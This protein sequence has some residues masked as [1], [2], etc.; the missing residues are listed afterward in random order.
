MRAMTNPLT[1]AKGQRRAMTPPEARLWVRLRVRATG[2]PNF[3]RQFPLKPYVLEFYCPEANL[4]V[5]VD[6][7]GPSADAQAA[8]REAYLRSKG[9]EIMRLPAAEVMA[10]PDA[11]AEAVWRRAIS[12]ITGRA[13]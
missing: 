10:D 13:E 11:A 8:P 7:W 2:R 4:A 12:L 1:P 9:L 6:G 5:E 3:H